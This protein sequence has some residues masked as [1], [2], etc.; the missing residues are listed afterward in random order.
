MSNQ[1]VSKPNAA[2]PWKSVPGFI[3]VALWIWSVGVMLSVLFGFIIVPAMLR[4][5]Q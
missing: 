4:A 3:R 1:F 2:T 5:M